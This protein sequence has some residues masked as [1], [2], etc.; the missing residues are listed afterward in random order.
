MTRPN[1]FPLIRGGNLAEKNWRKQYVSRGT[2]CLLDLDKD[3]MFHVEQNTEIRES[4]GE[5]SGA[6]DDGN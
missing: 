4:L 1:A 2:G 6:L 5:L 3:E